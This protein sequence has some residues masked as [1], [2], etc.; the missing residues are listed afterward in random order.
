[1][2]VFHFAVF[3]LHGIRERIGIVSTGATMRAV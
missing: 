1:M 3:G 2:L